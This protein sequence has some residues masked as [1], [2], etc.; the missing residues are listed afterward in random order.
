MSLIDARSGETVCIERVELP[1]ATALRLGELGLMPGEQ[2]RVV[3]N[4]RPCPIVLG[5]GAAQL[6]LGRDVGGNIVVRQL[7][8]RNPT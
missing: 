8:A 5:L 4:Q 2:L 7:T 6:M 1:T 3:R